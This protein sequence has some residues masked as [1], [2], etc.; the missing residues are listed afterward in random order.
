MRTGHGSDAVEFGS[1]FHD[2]LFLR[3]YI[4]EILFSVTYVTLMEFLNE[5]LWLI[6]D[7]S[8]YTFRLDFLAKIRFHSGA[9]MFRIGANYPNGLLML[10]Q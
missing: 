5:T 4:F 1:F 7:R 9:F 3:R 8:R 10:I 6:Q 2:Q